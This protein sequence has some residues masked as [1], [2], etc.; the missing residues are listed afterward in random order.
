MY[1]YT[2]IR[3]FTYL[4]RT[5]RVPSSHERFCSEQKGARQTERRRATETQERDR[6]TDRQ[7][8]TERVGANEKEVYMSWGVLGGFG[9]IQKRKL[10]L[11]PA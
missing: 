3:I 4:K 1:T 7:T 8:E 10:D 6:W 9:S 11:L 5:S 2:Y